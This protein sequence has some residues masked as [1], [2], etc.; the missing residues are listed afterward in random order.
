MFKAA[1]KAFEA[2]FARSKSMKEV[3]KSHAPVPLKT[4]LGKA[5]EITGKAL[6]KVRNLIIEK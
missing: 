1:R 4:V 5:L 3:I 2:Y 6:S